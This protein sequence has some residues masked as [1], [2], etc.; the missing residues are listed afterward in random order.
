MQLTRIK[1]ADWFQRAGLAPQD[2][3]AVLREAKSLDS[4]LSAHSKRLKVA[5]ATYRRTTQASTTTPQSGGALPPAPDEIHQLEAERTAIL[6]HHM[7]RS[8]RP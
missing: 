3:D 1:F 2:L 7:M 6:V 4:D 8:N 5:V